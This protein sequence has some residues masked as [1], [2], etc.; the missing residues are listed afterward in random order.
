MNYYTIT[1]TGWRR[2]FH[3]PVIIIASSNTAALRTA[4]EKR[5]IKPGRPVEVKQHGPTY[6]QL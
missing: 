3:C 4:L 1:Y 5:L 6:I 2:L